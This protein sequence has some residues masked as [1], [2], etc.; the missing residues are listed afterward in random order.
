MQRCLDGKEIFYTVHTNSLTQGM[1]DDVDAFDEIRPATNR[2]ILPPTVPLIWDT[3]FVHFLDQHYFRIISENPNYV[4][5]PP[6][7]NETENYFENS[8]VI[9]DVLGTGSFADAYKV[10]SMLDGRLYAVKKTRH[11]FSGF[12]DRLQKIKEVELM[13]KIGPSPYCVHLCNAWE[14]SGFLYIQTELYVYGSLENVLSEQN[15]D[16]PRIWN[17]LADLAL[18]ISLWSV[19]LFTSV[20]F[21]RV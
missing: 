2:L 5:E 21:N 7:N 16:E 4:P 17:S 13:W 8:F 3:P 20:F 9:L 19:L 14:Q 18:V 12:K 6:S 1:A 11:P 10:K 15:F